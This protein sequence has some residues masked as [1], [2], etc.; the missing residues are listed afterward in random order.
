[1]DGWAGGR[2]SITLVV[3]S[4][5]ISSKAAS[6]G[7]NTGS[8]NSSSAHCSISRC[9]SSVRQRMTTAAQLRRKAGNG[10]GVVILSDIARV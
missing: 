4:N 6:A 3:G 7:I 1:M 2:N 10:V 9:K 8:F 5:S